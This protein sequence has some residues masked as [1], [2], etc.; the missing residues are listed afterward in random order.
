M[1]SFTI[2]AVMLEYERTSQL[3]RQMKARRVELPLNK[4]ATYQSR[5]PLTGDRVLTLP[6]GGAVRSAYL[7]NSNPQPIPT[8]TI[9]STTPGLPGFTGQKP[10]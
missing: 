2:G 8:V 4:V 6:D 7:S 9:A 5:D 1:H 10:S 3:V